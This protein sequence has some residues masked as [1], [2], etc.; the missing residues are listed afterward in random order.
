MI[1]FL[2]VYS[3]SLSLPCPFF[4][5]PCLRLLTVSSLNHASP[6]PPFSQ[7]SLSYVVS[8]SSCSLNAAP[9]LPALTFMYSH[10]SLV[11]RSSFSPSSVTPPSPFLFFVKCSVF[12]SC[13]LLSLLYTLSSLSSLPLSCSISGCLRILLLPC[14]S[15]LF[16]RAFLLLSSF[17]RPPPPC[18]FLLVSSSSLSLPP[19]LLL[20]P[21]GSQASRLN[22]FHSL[23]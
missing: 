18:L 12:L 19:P 4:A 13:T 16:L 8:S 15:S 10:L 2:Q 1:F 14:P 3:G 23:E 17:L 9:S 11:C 21:A 5:L 7:T 22:G 20:L 6:F